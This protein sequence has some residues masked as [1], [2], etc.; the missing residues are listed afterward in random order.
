MTD[1]SD[2]ERELEARFGRPLTDEERAHL[3]E[4]VARARDLYARA[5][6]VELAVAEG[7]VPLDGAGDA[8]WAGQPGAAADADGGGDAAAAAA[9]PYGSVRR[10]AH[11]GPV[12][13]PDA[14]PPATG[15]GAR[16]RSSLGRIFGPLVAGA[17]AVAKW[18]A[19]IFKLK[20][21]GLFISIGAFQFLWRSWWLAIGF[22]G[23]IFVH[24]VG[25]MLEA[26]R[27]GVA[28]SWPQFVPFL[29]AY[30]LLKERPAN[31]YRNALVSIAGPALGSAAAVACWGA[32][33]ATNSQ[34]L[35]ALAH[36]GLFINLLNLVPVGFLDGGKIVDALEPRVWM[37]AILVLGIV[38]AVL[39]NGLLI[40]V[41]IV[42]ALEVW[43]RWKKI[44]A[45]AHD[46]YYAIG[47]TRM[48]AVAVAY[49]GLA[50]LLVAGM[51]AT[52][53]PR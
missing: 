41:L 3:H 4:N 10:T 13:N 35:K 27:Q 29:G 38:A 33:E 6:D 25:H 46:P 36:I 43:G 5:A 23:L 12:T 16:T 20:F 24:E 21:L 32:A 52:N 51:E 11:G 1:L 18:S 53:V 37:G 15:P 45:R 2:T 17:L 40:I 44:D 31:A 34:T 8:I 28:V 30:V 48:A 9:S 19:V 49:V 42:S 50:A 47:G 14:T 7:A 26:R 39:H 22:V